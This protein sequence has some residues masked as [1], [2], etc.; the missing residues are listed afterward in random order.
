MLP[1][2]LKDLLEKL[3]LEIALVDE[4]SISSHSNIMALLDRLRGESEG[5]SEWSSFFQCAKELCAFMGSIIESGKPFS[6]EHLDKFNGTLAKLKKI[7]SDEVS[8][9]GASSSEDQ[10]SVSSP[11][12]DAGLAVQDALPIEDAPVNL[13][14]EDDGELILEFISEGREH[15]DNIEQGLLVLE[16]H[17]T[18]A[19]TLNTIFRAFHTFKGSAGFL[20]LIPVNRLAHDLESLLDLARQHKLMITSEITDLILKGADCMNLSGPTR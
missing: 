11:G 17:P 10:S 8:G 16:E 20:N 18:D 4:D 1:E 13:N 9:D 14:V 12:G 15:L 19:D 7:P 5:K 2:Q 3:A 6:E